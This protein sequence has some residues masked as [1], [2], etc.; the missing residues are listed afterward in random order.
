MVRPCYY[1]ER[2]HVELH[3][4]HEG[5]KLDIVSIQ[6]PLNLISTQVFQRDLAAIQTLEIDLGSVLQNSNSAL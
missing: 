1:V 3:V 4:V 2:M 5:W 6:L